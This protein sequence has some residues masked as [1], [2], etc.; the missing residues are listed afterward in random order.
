MEVRGIP[1]VELEYLEI[2]YADVVRNPISFPLTGVRILT[3][4]RTPLVFWTSEPAD[5]IQRLRLCGVRV[6][7]GVT[8]LPILT[9]WRVPESVK[10]RSA[11]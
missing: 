2:A 11:P 1:T 6:G 8:R 3:F 5:V 7:E 9:A 10:A 4:V